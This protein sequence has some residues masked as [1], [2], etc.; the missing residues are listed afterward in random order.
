[1]GR[2]KVLNN[3]M[4]QKFIDY[5]MDIATRTSEL[6][7]AKRLQVGAVIV[8][9]NQILASGYNGMPSG[10]ENVCERKV[11]SRFGDINPHTDP[12]TYEYISQEILDEQ[13]PYIEYVGDKPVNRYTL[14]SKP[15][16]LH[17]ERNSLDKVA[18]SNE[19]T[20]GAVMFTTHAPCLECAKS[21]YNTGI[22]DVYYKEEYRSN[23]GIEFLKK[24]GVHVHKYITPETSV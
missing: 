17:A 20:L 21:I 13:Y 15:E 24:T 23:D 10:W 11:F 7:Y 22:T 8:K 9:G 5:F 6:S 2:I 16:V 4:K 19:S 18:A 12:I 1:M 3:I 14:V